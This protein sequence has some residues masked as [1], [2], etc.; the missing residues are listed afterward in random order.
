MTEQQ[1]PGAGSTAGD[2]LDDLSYEEL[3]QRAFDVA[4][5]RHDVGF[6][7]DLYNHT[8]AMHAAEAEGGSLGELSGSLIEMVNAAKEVFGDQADPELEPLF[9]A[10]F[11]TYLREHHQH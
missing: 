2:G 10:R 4:Q 9:R 8:R 6:F 7:V 3:R 1:D 11:I 5:H